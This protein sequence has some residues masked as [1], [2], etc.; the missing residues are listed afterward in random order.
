MAGACPLPRMRDFCAGAVAAATFLL[1][2]ACSSQPPTAEEIRAAYAAHVREDPV[3]EV[4]LRAKA[5]PA[6]IPNQE[7]RCTSDGNGHFDCRIRVIFETTSE[8]RSQDQLIH[9]RSE[10]GT[11]VIDSIN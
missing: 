4:G 9:I 6:V 8:P 11:W 7:P 5:A 3:H 2:S 10:G 1:V